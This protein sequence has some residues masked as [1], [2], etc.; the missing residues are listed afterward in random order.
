VQ[1]LPEDPV[2]QRAGSPELVRG[3]HLAENLS[4]ARHERVEPR[5][6]AEEMVGGGTVVEPVERRLHL[7]L[8]GGEHR[9]GLPLRGLCVGSGDIQ[10][11]AVARR[12]TDGLAPICRQPRRERLRL[13]P[14]ERDL[15]AHL[16]RRAVV[17]G[18]DEGETH[19]AKWVA[20][21]ASRTTTTRA[22]PASAT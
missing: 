16:D 17:R 7:G 9:N 15:L 14:A 21:R 5:R 10:L 18:A 1:R 13:V 20:G 4:L 11:R 22:K 19:H 12:E 6:D 8:E 2:E 3:T